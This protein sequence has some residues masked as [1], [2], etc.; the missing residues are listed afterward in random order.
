MKY[1]S[2]SFT[3]ENRSLSDFWYGN[4]LDTKKMSEDIIIQKIYYS[5]K[6]IIELIRDVVFSSNTS[7]RNLRSL[8]E[9]IL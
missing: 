9:V 7:S 5:E 2:N 1:V 4:S 3:D 8:K 6:Y